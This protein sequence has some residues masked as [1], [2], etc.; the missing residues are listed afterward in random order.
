VC[1]CKSG[2]REFFR[3]KFGNEKE[4]L[5]A[6]MMFVKRVEFLLKLSDLW[7]VLGILF[8]F[9]CNKSAVERALARCSNSNSLE[10][11]S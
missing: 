4:D 10:S 9:F 2:E 8:T 5:S 6:Q 3:D 7:A 1:Q 11:E